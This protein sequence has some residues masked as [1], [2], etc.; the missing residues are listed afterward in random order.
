M[1]VTD[2]Y[3]SVVEKPSP[4]KTRDSALPE[5]L[6]LVYEQFSTWTKFWLGILFDWLLIEVQLIL[7]R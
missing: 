3:Q 5:S 1:T 6:A 2:N 4:D 7:R